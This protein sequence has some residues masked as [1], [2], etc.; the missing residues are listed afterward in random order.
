L[1]QFEA[2]LQTT[3]VNAG[4]LKRYGIDMDESFVMFE[5][6]NLFMKL[7]ANGPVCAVDD[8]LCL[9]RLLPSS[10]TEKS[11]ERHAGERFATLDQ[12]CAA[13]P[14]IEAR[15]PEAF[16]EARARGSYYKARY[17]MQSGRTGAARD[18]LRPL[19]GVSLVYRI[20]YWL[21]ACPWA[22]KIVHDRNLK[23]RLTSL[24]LRSGKA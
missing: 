22:W 17:E 8:I 23:A 14:G 21:S 7:A 12:I 10:W 15:Y 13:N 5:D 24:F 20:L 4:Y 6:Y 18:T 2:N 19:A 1:A 16:R 11:L 9:C 3:I